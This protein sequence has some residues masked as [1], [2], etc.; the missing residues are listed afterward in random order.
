MLARRCLFSVG[1]R[2]LLASKTRFLLRQAA[3][4]PTLSPAVFCKHSAVATNPAAAVLRY[5]FPPP[6]SRLDTNPQSKRFCKPS[7]VVTSFSP[8]AQP[9]FYDTRFLLRQAAWTPTLSPSGFIN[10]TAVAMCSQPSAVQDSFPPPPSRSD[11]NPQSSGFFCK[12]SVVAKYPSPFATAV[13]R[14]SFP[15]PPGRVD[16]TLLHTAFLFLRVARMF[17]GKLSFGRLRRMDPAPEQR[18]GATNEH[19]H[20]AVDWRP[21]RIASSK[22]KHLLAQEFARFVCGDGGGRHSAVLR[23]SGRVSACWAGWG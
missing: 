22:S 8:S 19:K 18:K 6:P 23:R 20:T 14:Y 17:K 3:R 4:T 10:N 9:P 21:A 13:S 15:P 12:H 5:S 1:S 7:A 2:S 16:T 11:T